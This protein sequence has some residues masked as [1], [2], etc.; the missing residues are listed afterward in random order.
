MLWCK[1]IDGFSAGVNW[2][3]WEHV[4][5]YWLMCYEHTVE[6]YWISRWTLIIHSKRCLQVSARCA[7]ICRLRCPWYLTGHRCLLWEYVLGYMLLRD[8]HDRTEARV[9]QWWERPAKG[10][11]KQVSSQTVASR[12]REV[13]WNISAAHELELMRV[14][15]ISARGRY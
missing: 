3:C 15:Q 4:L 11:S 14:T 10:F 6:C 9:S 5:R 7:A 12:S 2:G 8:G 1:M 13:P